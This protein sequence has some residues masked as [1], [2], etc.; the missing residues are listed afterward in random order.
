M[1]VTVC[2]QTSFSVNDLPTALL[3]HI[4]ERLTFPNPVYQ[5]AAKTRLF[6]QEDHHRLSRAMN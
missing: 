1:Q 6:H 4:L 5:E 2:R 3:E